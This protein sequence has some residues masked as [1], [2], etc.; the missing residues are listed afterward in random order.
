MFTKENNKYWTD[1][2]AMINA[3]FEERKYWHSAK[4]IYNYKGYNIL[5]DH[6]IHYTEGRVTV[7][8]YVTG[9]YCKFVC[10]KKIYLKL[11]KNTMLSKFLNLFSEN[12]I[13]SLNQVLKS[14]YIIFCN[15][16]NIDKI[17]SK[18]ISVKLIS[19]KIKNLYIDTKDGIWG[20]NLEKNVYELA[21][22]KDINKTD[23]NDLQNIKIVFEEIIDQLQNYYHTKPIS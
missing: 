8:S 11:E 18:S 15:D 16:G 19:T 13:T 21:T 17:L 14:N 10:D 4:S 6:Y 7:G 2:S 5:F 20:G 3:N 23:Q 22:Y 1:F 9:V 12:K